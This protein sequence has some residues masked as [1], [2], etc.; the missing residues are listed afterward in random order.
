MLPGRKLALR[1]AQCS[2]GESGSSSFRNPAMEAQGPAIVMYGGGPRC[3]EMEVGMQ[4]GWYYDYAAYTTLHV[5]SSLAW[6]T[7]GVLHT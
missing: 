2:R 5:L 1:V 7:M 3:M 6:K 4:L